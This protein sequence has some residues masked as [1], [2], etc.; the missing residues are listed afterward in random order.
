M[1]IK[2]VPPAAKPPFEKGVLDLLKLLVNKSF[3]G[4]SGGDFFK[5]SP[6]V[7]N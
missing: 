1:R 7:Y 6:L 4:G 5:K 3:C 2:P